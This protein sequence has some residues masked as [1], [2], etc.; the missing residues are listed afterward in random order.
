MGM[1]QDIGGGVWRF[2]DNRN[3]V[4][5]PEDPEEMMLQD[6]DE[7]RQ[8]PPRQYHNRSFHQP[9]GQSSGAGASSAHDTRYTME[10]LYGLFDQFS[11]NSAESFNRITEQMN[12]SNAQQAAEHEATR[13]RIDQLGYR[14]D[15]QWGPFDPDAGN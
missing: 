3:Q 13:Q 11:T 2:R 7:R 1:C 12:A 8:S 14:M 4:W 9:A 10:G 15:R 5:D 6:I